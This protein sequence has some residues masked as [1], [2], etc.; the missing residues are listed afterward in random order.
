M[1]DF[2]AGSRLR[3]ASYGTCTMIVQLDALVGSRIVRIGWLIR[4]SKS[5]GCSWFAFPGF[6]RYCIWRPDITLIAN[7]NG[8]AF[9]YE[10]DEVVYC[11]NSLVQT[12]PAPET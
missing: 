5:A 4:P 6:C 8:I 7:E 11:R 10:D 12:C 9:E 1:A 2:C 3:K